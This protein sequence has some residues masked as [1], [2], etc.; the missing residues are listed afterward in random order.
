LQELRESDHDAHEARVAA[1]HVEAGDQAARLHARID[2]LTQAVEAE[3]ARLA[4][5]EAAH[6]A[7]VAQ[8]N[9]AAQAAEDARVRQVGALTAE[10]GREAA[11]LADRLAAVTQEARR[12]IE[13]AEREADTKV[14]AVHP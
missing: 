13:E 8:W 4:E 1:L 9:A 6:H 3:R 7:A 11:A 12:L 10:H 14:R 5:A 2:A